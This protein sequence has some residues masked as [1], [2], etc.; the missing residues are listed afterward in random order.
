M[1]AELKKLCIFCGSSG[2]DP[3]YVSAAT[4]LGK[5]LAN[6]QIQPTYGGQ[7]DWI[8]GRSR[9][10][11]VERRAKRVLGIIPVGLCSREISGETVGDQIKTK[12]MHERKRLMKRKP[13]VFIVYREDLDHG[14][15]V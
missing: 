3:S 12:D 2:N 11:G 8:D 14:R 15:V 6:A 1:T 9:G 10:S 4:R 7:I 5:T 13:T